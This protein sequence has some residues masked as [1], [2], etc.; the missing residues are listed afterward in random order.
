VQCEQ[1]GIPTVV[2]TTTKF[3]RLTR[4]I[5][6]S[7]GVPDLRIVVAP[8]PLGGT[9]PATITQWADDLVDEVLAQLT[10]C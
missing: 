7:Y 5:A 3:E 8:H 1:R 9:D 4:T 10:R 6:A 2:F